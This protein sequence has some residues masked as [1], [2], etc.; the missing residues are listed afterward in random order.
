MPKQEDPDNNESTHSLDS[1]FKGLDTSNFWKN[2][3]K[4]AIATA[5]EKLCRS[6][7][8]KNPVSRFGY[9]LADINQVKSLLS[10]IFEMTGV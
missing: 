4:K 5:N 8:E 2:G 10:C 1:D 6:T 9:D 7:Q 3:V